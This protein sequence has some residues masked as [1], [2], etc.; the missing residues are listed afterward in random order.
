MTSYSKQP[1]RLIVAIDFGTSRSGYAW[2]WQH[3]PKVIGRADWPGLKFK[4]PK[5]PTHLL[6]SPDGTLEK[7]GAEVLHGLRKHRE[8]E[9]VYEYFLYLI[10]G[11]DASYWTSTEARALN[12]KAGLV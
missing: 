8:A 1:F 2:A 6:Y 12:K 7:W 3:D 5:T 4:Y 11:S 9:K 10:S